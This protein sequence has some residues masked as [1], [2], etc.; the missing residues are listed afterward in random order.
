MGLTLVNQNRLICSPLLLLFRPQKST[1]FVVSLENNFFPNEGQAKWI[2]FLVVDQWDIELLQFG[3]AWNW[4]L[5]SKSRGFDNDPVRDLSG[6]KAIFDW[7]EQLLDLF[8]FAPALYLWTHHKD[9]VESSVYRK[10]M[11]KKASI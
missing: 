11:E 9:P 6:T 5:W 1:S 10:K 2:H 4:I 7:E 3:T 8:S